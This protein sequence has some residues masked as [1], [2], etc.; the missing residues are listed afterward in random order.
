MTDD[1][2]TLV[3]YPEQLED[4]AIFPLPDGVLFPHTTVRLHVFEPRYRQMVEDT[5]RDE[6]PLSV[7]MIAANGQN[8]ALGRPYLHDVAGIGI[9]VAHERLP[10]GRF[11]ILVRGVGRIQILEELD[12]DTPYRRVRAALLDDR[13]DDARQADV[14]LKTIQNCLFNVQTDNPDIVDFLMEAFTTVDTPGAAA[15][16]LAAVVF[17]DTLA[18]QSVLSEVDVVVRLDTILARLV[19]LVARGTREQM[20]NASFRN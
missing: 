10:G 4:L 9:V 8:D 2:P 20:E 1:L 3:V 13:V 12:V 7:A 16:I 19:D 11:N 5:L 17:G 14:L 18:R 6:A 15:D